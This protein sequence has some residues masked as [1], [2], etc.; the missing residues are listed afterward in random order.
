MDFILPEKIKNENQQIRRVGYELE[1]SGVDITT[2][3][4]MVAKLFSGNVEKKGKFVHYIKNTQYGDFR[5]ELDTRL[6]KEKPYEKFLGN[7]GV[8]INEFIDTNKLEE[9]IQKVAE[10][11]IPYELITPP[12]PIDEMNA[13]E[14]LRAKMQKIKAEGTR[15]S[16]IYAFGLHINIESP[17]TD[18]ETVRRYLQ[19]FLLLFPWIEKVSDIDFSRRVTPF[20]DSFPGSYRKKVLHKDYTPDTAVLIKD[21]IAE[22]ATRNRPLDMLPIFLEMDREAVG[23]AAEEVWSPRPAYH[24]RLPNC[25]IDDP[26]WR[27]AKEWNVW[28]A[29]ERIANDK[30][31]LEELLGE[32]Q[33]L[34]ETTLFGFEEQWIGRL[35]G[36]LGD[37]V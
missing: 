18:S 16:F 5:V 4:N 15:S 29:V 19:S 6:L 35:D 9:L 31:L 36:L 17:S 26:D 28:S 13:V 20:I 34:D 30:E 27:I 21:Y 24:Y 1:Y 8:D 14:T 23:E 22:N 33:Q 12:I 37:V 3:S 25:L 11:F 10:V 2:V 7:F 32:F